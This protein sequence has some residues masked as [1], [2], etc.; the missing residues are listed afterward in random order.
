MEN[1]E[2]AC[3]CWHTVGEVEHIWLFPLPLSSNNFFPPI[4]GSIISCRELWDAF[5][6]CT[7]LTGKAAVILFYSKT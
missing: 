7:P 1:V 6:L 3:L 4:T 2:M 5:F